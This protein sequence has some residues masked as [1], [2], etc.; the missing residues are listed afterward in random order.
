MAGLP[1]LPV[2]FLPL[3]SA[4]QYIAQERDITTFHGLLRHQIFQGAGSVLRNGHALV[5]AAGVWQ[6]RSKRYG[7]RAGSGYRA[8]RLEMDIPMVGYAE[9]VKHYGFIGRL[10]RTRQRSSC[11]RC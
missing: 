3:Y 1:G 5:T 2:R 10:A 4:E 9:K 8:V 11:S 6:E 7:E